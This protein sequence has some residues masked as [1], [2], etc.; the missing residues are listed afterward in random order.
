MEKKSFITTYLMWMES[1]QPA[2]HLANLRFGKTAPVVGVNFTVSYAHG[3]F[4]KKKCW[5]MVKHA[6][7]CS[8]MLHDAFVSA[9]SC[10][11]S[12]A[13]KN[14]TLS[15]SQQEEREKQNSSNNYLNGYGILIL[16]KGMPG[17][18]KPF[19]LRHTTLDANGE[20]VQTVGFT[21]WEG[22]TVEPLP[23]TRHMV[24]FLLTWC[25]C[26]FWHGATVLSHNLRL[27]Y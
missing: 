27:G 9:T 15:F 24:I 11:A 10:Y 18:V 7:C 1:S 26:Q 23:P 8:Y 2:P 22:A 14:I 5:D 6:F 20:V 12:V 16:E 3:F 25:F 17:E 21:S 4:G 19:H 13:R